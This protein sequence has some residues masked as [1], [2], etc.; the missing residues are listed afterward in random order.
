MASRWIV[1]RGDKECGPFT[2]PQL[3]SLAN[4]GQLRRTD[5]VTKQGKNRYVAAV[6]VKGLFDSQDDPAAKEVPAKSAAAANS[7]ADDEVLDFGVVEILEE[8]DPVI[9]LEEIDE[10]DDI[11]LLEDADDAEDPED[12]GIVVM[13]EDDDFDR[14]KPSP[15]ARAR[16]SSRDA[17][18]ARSRRGSSPRRTPAKPAKPKTPARKNVAAEG[19]EED[20]ENGPWLNLVYGLACVF[21]GICFFIALGEEDPN[22]WET[23]GR[24]RAV[25]AVV[26]LIYNIGGRWTVL[27]LALLLSSLFFWSAFNQFRKA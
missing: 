14:P 9:V 12:Y 22:T 6:K 2:S 15:S 5:L 19:D 4:S 17:P 13:D 23:S 27:G 20:E 3:K 7:P 1:R 18:P 24:N 10:D 25:V 8:D 21:G 16:K 26:K 11:I